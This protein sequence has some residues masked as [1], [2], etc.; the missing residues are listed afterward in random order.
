MFNLLKACAIA[1]KISIAICLLSAC[2][3]NIKK[4]LPPPV[5]LK[6]YSQALGL[7]KF[8]K[9][10]DS[11][12]KAIQ[13]LDKATSSDSNFFNA[14]YNKLPFLNELKDYKKCIAVINSLNRIKPNANDIYLLSGVFL[15]KIGDTTLA[16]NYFSKSLEICSNV[17]DT[18]HISNNDYQILLGN[19]AFN[20]IMTGDRAKADKAFQSLYLLQSDEEIKKETLAISK[21]TKQQLEAHILG[22]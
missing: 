5:S 13:L 8:V 3:S 6:Y 1:L 18:M 10:K 14:H 4:H 22:N 17:L 11:C 20:L 19:K 15:D 2:K 7:M 21:M 16:N 12:R 9:E